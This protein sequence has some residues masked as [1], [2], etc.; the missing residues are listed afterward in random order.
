MISIIITTYQ[1][2]KTLPKAIQLIL[3]QDFKENFE[4]LVVGPD[5]ETADIA[6]RFSEKY[7]EAKYLKDKGEGK[8]AALDLALA[9]AQGRILVL[10][11]G[12][13]FIEQS[14]LKYLLQPF[15][16]SGGK[17]KMVGAVSGRP[18][19]L[20]SR[21]NLFGYWSHFL[22]DA[23]H[24]MRLKNQD[25]PCSGY[26]YAFRNNIIS[27][28]SENLF[29]EDGVITQE[30]RNRGYLVVYAPQA[31]VYV[32][33][34]ESFRDW[35]KQKIRSTGGYIQRTK[36]QKNERTEERKIKKARSFGQ[37]LSSGMKLFFVY[38]KSIKEFFW[39]LLLYLARIYLWLMIFWSIKIKNQKFET[40]WQR[41][42]STK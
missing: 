29:S 11:D 8:P 39:T 31:K 1:E 40:I 34:P 14:S 5:Q 37:E 4:V 10:T 27:H 33:Y 22:T 30:I 23:A 15:S 7:S 17:D 28:I 42:E 2:P 13:V 18:I 21:K 20:N 41:T 16:A 3:N 26:L 35:L 19:S 6:R 9:Q 38:P 24:Q 36:E 12:D 32:K 25:F